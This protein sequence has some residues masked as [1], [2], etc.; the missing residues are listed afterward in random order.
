MID[1]ELASFLQE[2]IAIH[3][4]TRNAHLEPNGARVV[5]VS[6]DADSQHVV[7]YVP[8]SAARSV[9]ADLASNG[10]AAIVFARPP[11]ERACQLKG[12]FAGA[13]DAGDAER[14][15]VEAQWGRWLDRLT[16][17]G[18]PHE[19][20]EQWTTWPC[21]AVRV[22]VTAIFNQTPGPGAG[23]PIA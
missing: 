8:E 19:T 1:A 21:V 23:A 5:A 15:M 13:R 11:D 16:T 12:T 4:G 2:G 14:A 22:R 9:L 10:E 3:L 6:V 20:F 7:A 17:I 18:C